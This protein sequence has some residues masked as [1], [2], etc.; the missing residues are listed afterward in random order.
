MKN[1]QISVIFSEATLLIG[2]WWVF[3]HNTDSV[4]NFDHAELSELLV[5]RGKIL[6]HLFGCRLQV[7]RINRNALFLFL[8]ESSAVSA[9][10]LIVAWQGL[11]IKFDMFLQFY[12]LSLIAFYLCIVKK[13]GGQTGQQRTDKFVV[14]EQRRRCGWQQSNSHARI[15]L[16]FATPNNL[17]IICLSYQAFLIQKRLCWFQM[18]GF[19]QFWTNAGSLNQSE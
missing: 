13:K 14:F 8:W 10:C 1:N 6:W 3:T 12:C 4:N 7:R 9:L 16:L 5:E 17:I 19:S 18:G 15:T 11:H 2:D